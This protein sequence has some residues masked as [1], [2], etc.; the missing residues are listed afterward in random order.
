VARG[1]HGEVLLMQGGIGSST[2]RLTS[3]CSWRARD[4]WKT[5]I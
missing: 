2:R 4:L 1:T 5:F 3:V